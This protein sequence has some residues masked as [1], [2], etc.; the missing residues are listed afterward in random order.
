MVVTLKFEDEM[1]S[2][3]VLLCEHVRSD[4]GFVGM[5]L[6]IPGPATP[7]NQDPKD[8]GVGPEP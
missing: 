7:Q 2:L 8:R 3:V 5:N 1:N 4:D 6:I